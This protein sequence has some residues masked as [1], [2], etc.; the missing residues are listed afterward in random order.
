MAQSRTL[1]VGMDVHKES[2]AVAYVSQDY[3]AAVISLGPVGTRPG[4][5]DKLIRQWQAKSKPLVFVY[6][7]G[8]GGSWLSRSLTT[9]GHGGWGVAPALIPQKTGDRVNT[10]R[11]DALPLARLLRSGDHTPVSGPAVHDA[12]RRALSRARSSGPPLPSNSSATKRSE[13]SPTTRSGSSAWHRHA[14]SRAPPGGA[15]RVLTRCQPSVA[16]RVRWLSLP[17]LH[18]ATCPASLTPDHACM[19]LA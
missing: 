18:S 16:C 11:R 14:T 13:R 19:I 6:A 17:A 12:T 15:A 1:D 8:P 3:G 5:I 7:A 9:T 4:D 10:D 2:I